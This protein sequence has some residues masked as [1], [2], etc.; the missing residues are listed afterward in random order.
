MAVESFVLIFVSAI[1]HYSGE[2]EQ[3]SK[4]MKELQVNYQYM[5]ALNERFTLTFL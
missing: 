4:T 5:R 3:I 1:Q 2:V